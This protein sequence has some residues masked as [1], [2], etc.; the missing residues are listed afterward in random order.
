MNERV[1]NERVKEVA[2]VVI[3]SLL[4]AIGINFLLFQI[5]YLKVELLG[6]QLLHIICLNGHQVL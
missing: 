2:L 1:I 4:F 3:G 6:L 5:G